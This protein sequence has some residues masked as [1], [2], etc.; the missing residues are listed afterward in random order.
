MMIFWSISVRSILLISG[1]FKA[2]M[3]HTAA[4]FGLLHSIVNEEQHK[5]MSAINPAIME[6]RF[7]TTPNN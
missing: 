5:I 6:K 7:S 4:V 1:S 3:L 2:S